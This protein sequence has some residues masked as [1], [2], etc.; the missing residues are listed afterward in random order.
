M[1]SI[2]DDST[3][4]ISYCKQDVATLST[5]PSS[6]IYS[7]QTDRGGADSVNHCET[8]VVY[9]P[10]GAKQVFYITHRSS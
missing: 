8:T 9:R 3:S 4:P 5:M 6:S 10:V 2:I 7:T 1:Q